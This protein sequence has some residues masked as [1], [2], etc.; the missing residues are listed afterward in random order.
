LNELK[1]KNRAENLYTK[2]NSRL[3]KGYLGSI[4]KKKIIENHL[5]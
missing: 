1:N 2:S 3:N 4:A 5:K